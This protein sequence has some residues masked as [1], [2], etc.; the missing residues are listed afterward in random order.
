MRKKT[1]MLLLVAILMFSFSTSAF[2]QANVF[3]PKQLNAGYIYLFTYVSS[4]SNAIINLKLYQVTASGDQLIEQ[5]IAGALQ[6]TRLEN[7]YVGVAPTA[8]QYKVVVDAPS[9]V[10]LSGDIIN[11]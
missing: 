5:R 1:T 4:P 6:G 3:G 9:Y 2:A 11:R 8:G 7:F 10:S